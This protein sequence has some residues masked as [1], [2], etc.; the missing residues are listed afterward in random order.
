[1]VGVH[2]V[3]E[4]REGPFTSWLG[5]WV[6]RGLRR[7]LRV[8]LGR[9]ELVRLRI[10]TELSKML[11]AKL[12]GASNL[13]GCGAEGPCGCRGGM[14]RGCGETREGGRG[15]RENGSGERC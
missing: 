15:Q 13:V 4:V 8:T 7:L 1:M 3:L 11:R 14:P 2:G 10:R 6:G 12:K 9:W 5:W